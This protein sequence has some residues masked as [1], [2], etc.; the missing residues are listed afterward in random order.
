MASVILDSQAVSVLSERKKSE[1]L[2]RAR[3]AIQILLSEGANLFI[4]ASTI[5][6]IR[7]GK[8]STGV[9]RVLNS[10]RIINIDR[11]IA[12]VSAE[13]LHKCQLGSE[14]LADALVVGVASQ[15]I[16]GEVYIITSDPKDLSRLSSKVNRKIYVIS[17]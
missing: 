5:A 9:D 1:S 3:A 8:Y 12:S 16:A 14:N 10:H 13:V 17:I 11:L 15:A 6:E 4:P 7:R 2:D